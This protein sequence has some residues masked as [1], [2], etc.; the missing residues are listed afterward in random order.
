M[1][2]PRKLVTKVEMRFYVRL[3]LQIY[4]VFYPK[5]ARRTGKINPGPAKNATAQQIDQLNKNLNKSGI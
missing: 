1:V 5:Y 4:P 3:Y 2:F